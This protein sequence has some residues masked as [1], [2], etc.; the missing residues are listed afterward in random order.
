MRVVGGKLIASEE[1]EQIT[2]FEWAE[3]NKHRYPELALL[4]HIPNEG[5]RGRKAAG[6]LKAIGVKSGVP[7]LCLPVRRG[8]YGALYI[9]LKAKDGKVSQAQG[10]WLD[11][12]TACGNAA[13]L[14]Y[15]ADAA[16]MVIER[17]LLCEKYHP[18]E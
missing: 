17:Y 8:R 13:A 10:E 12:L 3:R 14:C 4:Y 18:T 15:G 9:E 7:D 6:V 2:V 11:A 16:I 1:E 5:K